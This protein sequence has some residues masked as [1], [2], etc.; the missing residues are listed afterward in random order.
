MFIYLILMIV[1][2]AVSIIT[3]PLLLLNLVP[4]F[5]VTGGVLPFGIDAIMVTAVST[6]K[7]VMLIFPPFQ[8]VYNAALLLLGFE[9]V[10]F[11][12]RIILGSRLKDHPIE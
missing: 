9:I 11:V 10:M 1:Y 2:G 7:A 5:S 4:N 8:V 6:F 3:S 12:L